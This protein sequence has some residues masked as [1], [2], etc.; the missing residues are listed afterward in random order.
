LGWL[1]AKDKLRLA[2]LK[3]RG[4]AKSFYSTQ[5]ELK[6]DKAEYTDFRAAFVQRLK[7]K[8]RDQNNYTRLQNASQ[9]KDDG[10]EMY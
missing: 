4:V 1:S 9:E 10:P 5:P 7:K 6:G 3:L 2:R 8:Q